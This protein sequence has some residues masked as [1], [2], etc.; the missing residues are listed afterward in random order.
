LDVEFRVAS[1]VIVSVFSMDCFLCHLTVI[2]LIL[3]LS[4]GWWGYRP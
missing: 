3:F 4:L 2:E 1:A